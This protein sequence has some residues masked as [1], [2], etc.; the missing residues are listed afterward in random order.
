M[1]SQP[2][3]VSKRLF[4]DDDLQRS[5][6]MKRNFTG[7]E[8]DRVIGQ[9]IKDSRIDEN[10]LRDI[11]GS[12]QMWRTVQRQINDRKQTARLPWSPAL[13]VKRWL[14]IGVPTVAAAAVLVT[15][16]ISTSTTDQTTARIEQPTVNKVGPT[17]EI[18]PVVD[19]TKESVPASADV[20]DREIKTSSKKIADVLKKP[21]LRKA[22][23]IASTRKQKTAATEISS[24]FIALSYARNPESGQLVRVKVPRSMMVSL[25]LVAS[26][27]QPTSLVDAEVVVGDDGLTRAIRFIR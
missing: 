11:A 18:L 3:A 20:P 9:L 1:A 23:T 14:M 10:E 22:D 15:F 5:K 21:M 24:D 27:E 13:A 12:S 25:G 26:V 7:T 16:L 4:P 8:V 2:F 19:N 17:P 6:L